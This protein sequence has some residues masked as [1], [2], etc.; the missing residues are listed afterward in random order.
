[1]GHVRTTAGCIL[2]IKTDF[3]FRTGTL[4]TVKNNSDDNKIDSPRTYEYL[5]FK[6]KF[7]GEFEERHKV[8]NDLIQKA[9]VSSGQ[10]DF[11]IV[12]LNYKK[13]ICVFKSHRAP[14]DEPMEEFSKEEDITITV[15][16]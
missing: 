1:M 2:D 14:R 3:E 5:I 10:T 12:H 7:G 11:S 16:A 9:K 4:L 13:N 6:D 8:Y 15:E